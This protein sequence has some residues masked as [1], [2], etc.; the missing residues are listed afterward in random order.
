MQVLLLNDK[1]HFDSVLKEAADNNR[2]LVVDY[3]TTVRE[4]AV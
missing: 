1:A 2:I 4:R 3:Y